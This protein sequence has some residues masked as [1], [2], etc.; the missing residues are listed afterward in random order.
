MKK[1]NGDLGVQCYSCQFEDF[2]RASI[3]ILCFLRIKIVPY[4]TR[5]PIKIKKL[6]FVSKSQ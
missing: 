4:D 5:M 2:I 3:S 6:L 1:W